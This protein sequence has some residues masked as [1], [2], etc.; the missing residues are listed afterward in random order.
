MS[1]GLGAG[2]ADIL[3]REEVEESGT[4]FKTEIKGGRWGW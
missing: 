2:S 3:N 1:S 4:E